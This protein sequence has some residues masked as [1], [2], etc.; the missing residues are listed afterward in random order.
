MLGK[1]VRL[2][3]VFAMIYSVI[4]I[5]QK[6]VSYEAVQIVLAILFS[7]GGIGWKKIECYLQKFKDLCNLLRIYRAATGM[8]LGSTSTNSFCK[9]VWMI[10]RKIFQGISAR[11]EKPILM[12]LGI[13]VTRIVNSP[14]WM[15]A[16]IQPD[17]SWVTIV[18]DV[19]IQKGVIE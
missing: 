13:L 9:R 4:I 6:F 1:I 12:C 14:Y 3:M 2:L 16:Y 10:T 15:F 11:A 8:F 7:I 5:P 19:S 18:I 17:R